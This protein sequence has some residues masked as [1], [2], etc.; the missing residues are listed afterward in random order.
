MRK[1]I[2]ITSGICTIKIKVRYAKKE[3]VF[4]DRTHWNKRYPFRIDIIFFKLKKLST[5]SISFHFIKSFRIYVENVQLSTHFEF[6]SN[7]CNKFFSDSQ[8]RYYFILS[9]F[10]WGCVLWRARLSSTVN[11]VWCQLCLVDIAIRCGYFCP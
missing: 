8:Q 5:E 1:K 7:K 10:Y 11:L 4:L 2:L 3:F 9:T 6:Y